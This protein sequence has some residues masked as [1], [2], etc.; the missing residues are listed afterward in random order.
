MK[1]NI[2][3]CVLY[4]L[5]QYTYSQLDR[6]IGRDSQYHQ[7][8]P[9]PDKVDPIEQTLKQ[10][11]EKLSLD[12]FQ[13][14]ATKVFLQENE[15]SAEKILNSSISNEEKKI[16][17]DEAVK[18]FDEKFLKILNPEQIKIYEELKNNSKGKSKKKKKKKEE[19]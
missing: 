7:E 2:F 13:E 4:M 19:N 16:K 15:K 8:R 14:A 10:L 11:K 3:I 18:D 6:S 1:K 17:L 5:C 9:I 12:S